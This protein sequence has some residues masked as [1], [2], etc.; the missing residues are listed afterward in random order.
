LYWSCQNCESNKYHV[1]WAESVVPIESWFNGN[2]NHRQISSM[3]THWNES[4]PKLAKMRSTK[5]V[6]I[7][8]PRKQIEL[9]LNGSSQ[10]GSSWI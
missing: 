9:V 10:K 6:L 2:V 4:L 3:Q 1:N 5:S 8:R 7:G